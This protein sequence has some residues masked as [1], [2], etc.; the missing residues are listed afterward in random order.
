MRDGLPYVHLPESAG[1]RQH[2]D[3]DRKEPDEQQAEL[4]DYFS[5]LFEQEPP[6]DPWEE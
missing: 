5:A 3:F 1:Q 2:P 4:D 6:A